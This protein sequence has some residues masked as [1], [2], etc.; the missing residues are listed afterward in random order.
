MQLYPCDHHASLVCRLPWVITAPE[1]EPLA[2][3]PAK[4]KGMKERQEKDGILSFCGKDVM[5]LSD[6]SYVVLRVPKKGCISYQLTFN[7]QK[8]LHG[9]HRKQRA[10]KSF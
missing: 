7:C 5:S 8:N 1:A 2:A 6:P 3:R 4:G 9:T 10:N